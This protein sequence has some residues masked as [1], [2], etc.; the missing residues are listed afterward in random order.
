MDSNCILPWGRESRSWFNVTK[1]VHYHH[2]MCFTSYSE[3]PAGQSVFYSCHYP[4]ILTT[5]CHHFYILFHGS[6]QP[7]YCTFCPILEKLLVCQAFLELTSCLTAQVLFLW[8]DQLTL[9]W[10]HAWHWGF[11]HRGCS[12]HLPNILSS[13]TYAQRLP[14]PHDLLWTLNSPVFKETF[15]GAWAGLYK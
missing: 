4:Y 13:D 12:Y 10:A 5:I 11:S 9:P 7:T 3:A 14:V 2:L 6:E 8:M 1:P 15:S